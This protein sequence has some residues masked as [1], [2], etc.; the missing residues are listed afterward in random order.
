VAYVTQTTLSLDDTR[1]VIAA[2]AE[3]Y[4]DL[5]GPQLADI[6]YATQNRQA[7][8]RALARRVELVLV[9]GARNSSNASR[10]QEVAAAAGVRAKLLATADELD[11]AWLLPRPGAVGVT[12]GASTPDALVQ[13]VCRRL[14]ELGSS[15][16]RVLPGLVERVHFRLPEGLA[17]ARQRTMNSQAGAPMAMQ[18][19]SSTV[20]CGE[21]ST[22]NSRSNVAAK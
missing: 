12:A 20:A 3:R 2:L 21:T 4:A 19:V 14:Q 11:P 16:P 6:C 9:V 7:A 15:P 17:Q 5:Q 8:V 1:Q 22:L 18:A 13:G 10:L